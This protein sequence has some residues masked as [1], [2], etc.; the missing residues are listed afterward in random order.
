MRADLRAAAKVLE[1]QLSGGG[2]ATIS[3]LNGQRFALRGYRVERTSIVGIS[4]DEL[5]DRYAAGR[6]SVQRLKRNGELISVTPKPR[7]Q[8]GD[9]LVIA[10]QRSVLANAE[11]EIGPEFDDSETLAVP[12]QTITVVVTNK[13]VVGR[14]SVNWRLTGRLHAGCIWNHSS[15]VK[16]RSL[17]KWR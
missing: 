1:A 17:A 7:L 16:R 11:R 8:F 5:E 14:P 10:A 13:S 2:A 12:M 15:V 9:Q 3:L 4:T 6:L